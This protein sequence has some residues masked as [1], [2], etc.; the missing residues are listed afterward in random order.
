MAKKDVKYIQEQEELEIEAKGVEKFNPKAKTRYF[1]AV[2]YPE[3]MIPNW[4]DE[5]D[6][7]IQRPFAYCIHDKDLCKDGVTLRKE[8]VHIMIAFNN[9]TTTKHAL[10][11]YNL[12]SQKGKN[13]K[14]CEMVINV[15]NKFEYLIH[16]TEKAKKD[17]KYLYD[18][19]ER[20]LGNS[21][22]I[23]AYEQLSLS[24]KRNIRKSIAAIINKF[25]FLSFSELDEYVREHLSDEYY[26]EFTSHQGYFANLVRGH[27]NS[28]KS[29]LTGEQDAI[30]ELIALKNE[31]NNMD[32][33]EYEKALHDLKAQYCC[34]SRK[35]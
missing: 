9:S 32:A 28:L 1:V 21:F 2:M 24:D 25:H 29:E 4:K 27:Y 6:D 30:N 10:E 26:D 16:N 17:G 7:I 20:I 19:S 18:E 34:N 11:V 23:G 5:I 35:N 22:D 14:Y 12:L 8:H 31:K 33:N 13:I 15:R 3:S